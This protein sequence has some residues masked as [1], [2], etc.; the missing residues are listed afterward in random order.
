MGKSTEQQTGTAE[1]EEE[2]AKRETGKRRKE[3][4]MNTE[5]GV[6]TGSERTR[7]RFRRHIWHESGL[8]GQWNRNM[9]GSAQSEKACGIYHEGAV[10]GLSDSWD[11]S[12]QRR[13]GGKERGTLSKKNRFFLGNMKFVRT[14]VTQ[15]GMIDASLAQLVEHDT[16][17]VGV[18]GSSP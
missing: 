9:P 17:N 2:Q 8:R 16:L 18:Q 7:K 4:G 15:S 10:C 11:R 5:R 14:F 13:I 1:V 3:A 12:L 6:E